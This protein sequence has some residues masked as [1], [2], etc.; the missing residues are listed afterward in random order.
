MTQNRHW[1]LA[2]RPI[3]N[4]YADAFA[5]CKEPVPVAGEG[6]IVIANKVLS[7]D[8]G[9]R[10]YMTDREDSY[11]PGTPLGDKLIGTVL[12]VVTETRHPT[13]AVGDR[14]RC[15]GQ[16]ADYSLVDPATTY[17]TR[18]DDA[19][20]DLK[21]Y[22]GI[23]GANG[24]TAY[25]GVVE[26]GA[27]KAGETFVVSA[28][29]GCTG[30]MAGQIAKALGCRVIGIAGGAAKCALLTSEYGFDAAIDY[31]AGDAADELA[32]LCPEGIDLYFDNVGGE[33][34]DAALGQ[35]ALYGRVAICGLLTNYTAQG[36]VPGPYRFDQVL[37]KRLRIEG[38]FS[39]DFYAREAE[40]NPVL[41]R[42]HAAGQLK[43]PFEVS[44]GLEAIPEAFTKLFTGGNI[45]KVVVE[46]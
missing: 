35:M 32:Q 31:K 42:W 23:Y 28:A 1:I 22:V 20:A 11:Q 2:K 21:E 10:M 24:W 13:Y 39:P 44:H 3:G 16:W 37:M 9:T 17:C 38:F 43:L 12:G 27:A 5:L 33:I 7:M 41:A 46:L 6:Q 15:Y 34:L 40:F 29:A 36:P 26:T 8:S 25:V 4:G 19:H 14:V 18:L 30:I 45:G